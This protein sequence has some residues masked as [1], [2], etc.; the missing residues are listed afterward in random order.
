VDVVTM[1]LDLVLVAGDEALPT[2]G[3]EL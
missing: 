2:L 1:L 3:R